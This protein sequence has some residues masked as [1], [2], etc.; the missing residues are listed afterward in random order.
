M[1]RIVIDTNTLLSMASAAR[2]SPLLMAWLSSQFTVYM[3]DDMLV[4]LRRVL[5]YPKVQRFVPLQRGKGFVKF[6]EQ[7]ATFVIVA[8]EYP[9][10]RDPKDN[11]VVAT[12]V[13]AQADY[14]ITTD[15]DLYDDPQ[16]VTALSDLGIQILPPNRFLMQML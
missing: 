1:T 4:E 13:A 8:D 9:R 14:L 7:R 12:A 11:M 6:I 5:D 2:Q 16:L 15:K 10:C 3:S